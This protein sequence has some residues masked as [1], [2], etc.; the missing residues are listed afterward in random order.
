MSFREGFLAFLLGAVLGAIAM[1]LQLG[2]L[3]EYRTYG[4][5]TDDLLYGIVLLFPSAM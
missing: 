3:V 2:L 4:L 1:L 5:Y